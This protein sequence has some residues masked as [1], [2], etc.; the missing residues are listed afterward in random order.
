MRVLAHAADAIAAAGDADPQRGKIRIQTRCEGNTVLISVS[1]T[2]CGIPEEL[3]ERIFEPFFTTK[4]AGS[5]TGQGL[6]IARST[7][8]EKHFGTIDVETDVGRGTTF[9]IRLPVDGQTPV[10]SE[11]LQ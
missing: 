6:S 9:L 1:D 8:V 5:G 7:V 11:K 10:C 2:G 3:R 4:A